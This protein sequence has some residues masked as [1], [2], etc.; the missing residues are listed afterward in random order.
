MQKIYCFVDE[1]G[2][3]T[4]G[5]KFIVSVIIT[6]DRDELEN[7]LIKIE[8]ESNKNKVKWI[9]TQEIR[10]YVY[11]D[12]ISKLKRTKNDIYYSVFEDSKDYKVLT[13]LA[14][15]KA[16]KDKKYLNNKSSIFIDGLN[17][18]EIMW[19]SREIR[20]HGLKTDKIRGLK[21]QN[22]AIIRLADSV[23]GFIFEA[24]SGIKIAKKYLKNMSEKRKPP[25]LKRV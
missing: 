4:L 15:V 1:S 24:E 7:N 17:K 21:D 14:V 12:L 3:H 2:Q 8:K 11:L 5:A 25:L 9:Q 22:S 10:K 6:Q 19:F 13:V 20:R 23:A 18:H 16:V